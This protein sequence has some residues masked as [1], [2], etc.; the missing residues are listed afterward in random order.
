MWQRQRSEENGFADDEQRPDKSH[1]YFVGVI[2]DIGNELA[3]S[4]QL[5]H[6]E[7]T[8]SGVFWVAMGCFSSFWVQPV[9]VGRVS[10]AVVVVE[11]ST[12]FKIAIGGADEEITV[13]FSKISLV[14]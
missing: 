1:G 3:S 14:E 9:V 7:T 5:K 11:H 12:G 6:V 2:D 8:D 4:A 13:I 10:N